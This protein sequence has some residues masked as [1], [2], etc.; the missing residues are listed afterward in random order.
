MTEFSSGSPSGSKGVAFT[1]WLVS[2]AAGVLERKSSRRGFIIGSAMVGS[3][4]AVAGCAPGTQPGTPYT[5]ITDCAGGLCTDGYTE[6]C[7]TINNGINACPP[8]TLRRRLV[9]RRLLQLLQRHP[10]LHGLHAELLRSRTSATGSAPA[11]TSARC[12]GGCDTRRVY[13]NYFRYGQC[14]QEIGV[15]GP[16]ACRVVT[17]APPYTVAE[18]ACTTALA[19]DNSTAEHA[20]AHGCT[21]PPPPSRRRAAVDRRRVVAGAPGKL[22]IFGP[23]CRRQRLSA[24]DLD[25]VARAFGGQLGPSVTSAST[26]ASDAT[27]IYVFG[28]GIDDALWYNRLAERRRGPAWQP[29]RRAAHRPTRSRS[30]TPNG[31]RTCSA[32]VATT[33]CGYGHIDNGAWSGWSSDCRATSTSDLAAVSSS[34][35]L[36]RVRPRVDGQLWYPTAQR[37]RVRS[38]GPRSAASLTADARPRSATADRRERRSSSTPTARVDPPLRRLVGRPGRRWAALGGRHVRSRRSTAPAAS[39]VFVRGTDG[40]ICLQPADQRELDRL[41][42][43]LAGSTTASPVAVVGHERRVA[44]SCAASTTRS[45]PAASPTDGSASSR[46]V[47]P[48]LRRRAHRVT[49]ARDVR[50]ERARGRRAARASR[51]WSSASGAAGAVDDARRRARRRAT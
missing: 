6:F 15:L 39:Y 35:G 46:S 50:V 28:R 44:C 36:L 14:H 51:R 22:A 21:P 26:S 13:C 11:A 10:L 30:P 16:I 5:H 31:D 33:S 25:R 3:A 18:Y 43:H 23:G 9:A 2:K 12:G 17:C 45:G 38:R 37:R 29:R 1:N 42:Q 19:V 32:A 34:Y 47:A 40:H 27:G 20:P 8:G 4:V 48:S 41:D 7:C 49:G 24:F